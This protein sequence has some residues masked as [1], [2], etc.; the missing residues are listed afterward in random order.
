MP[1]TFKRNAFDDYEAYSGDCLIG[2]IDHG[3]AEKGDTE[4]TWSIGAL[5][6]TPQWQATGYSAPDLESAMQAL[7]SSFDEWLVCA[8]LVERGDPVET[9]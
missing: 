9:G 4:Y 8:H 1:L 7:Q 6:P 3:T 2:S 5:P